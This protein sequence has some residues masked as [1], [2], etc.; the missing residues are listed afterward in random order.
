VLVGALNMDE[1]AYGFTTENSH[2]GP[3]RNPHDTTRVAG[4]SSGGSAAAV[5]AGLV[6][7]ALG[8]DTNGSIRVPA[9]LCGVFGLKP[10]FGRLSRRGAFPFVASLDHV[11]PFARCVAD[12]AACYDALQGADPLDPGCAPRTAEPVAAELARGA[13]GLRIGV[14]GGYFDAMSGPLAREA[15]ARVADCLGARRGVELPLAQEGR[16][17]AFVVTASEG[18]ALHLPLLRSRYDDFEPLSRDRF[19]AGSLIPAAWYLKAQRVRATYR[20]AAARVFR[21]FDVLVAAATPVEAQPIGTE[22]IEL[23][24]ARLPARASMGVLTQPISCIGLPVVAAPVPLPGRLPIAV[25]LIAAPWREVDAFRVAAVLERA[26]VSFSPRP[27][28][29]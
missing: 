13:D 15:V 14:L 27:P 24:G 8:T 1:Y 25:Q 5:A 4:G 3:A 20:D 28:A 10:T 22:W 18:G 23:N 2:D 6:P 17:A 12:L 29:L 21:D 7:L 16:A 26:G 11:G 19:I 9:S